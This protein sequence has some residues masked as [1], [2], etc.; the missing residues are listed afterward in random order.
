ME[1]QAVSQRLGRSSSTRASK[2]Q[3]NHRKTMTASGYPRKSA[4]TPAQSDNHRNLW[5]QCETPKPL[6]PQPSAIPPQLDLV[7]VMCSYIAKHVGFN[8]KH[9]FHDRTPLCC[10]VAF[11]VCFCNENFWLHPAT[12]PQR[13]FCKS[14]LGF[15]RWPSISRTWQ[16]L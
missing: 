13:Q 2:N 7:S 8:D 10:F 1:S 15:A 16:Y 3:E 4:G 6:T 5:K 12:I 14:S 11:L 9:L